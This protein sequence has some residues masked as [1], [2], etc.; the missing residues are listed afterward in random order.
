MQT[1]GIN[2]VC[3]YCG[4]PV[5]GPQVWANGQPFH[6]ECTHGPDYKPETFAPCPVD[7]PEKAELRRRIE[8][9]ERRMNDIHP[10]VR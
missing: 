1:T 3:G 4:R 5:V 6:P 9:L 2:F 7:D 8:A 10:E